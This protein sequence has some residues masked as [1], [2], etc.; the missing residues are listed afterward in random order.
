MKPILSLTGLLLS[1]SLWSN[2]AAAQAAPAPQPSSRTITLKESLKM[3]VANSPRLK[4]SGLEQ[5]RLQYNRKATTGAG[6]PQV[7]LSGSYDDYLALPTQMIPNIFS[8]PPRP[9]EKIPVQ[10]GTTY[11]IT[12]GLDISQVVYNQ[13][14][15]VGLR[16]ARQ[17]EQQ[18]ELVTE[19][20]TIDVVFDV[21][22][23][24]YL[25][26]ITRQ[27]IRNMQSN[28][29][30]IVKAERIASSQYDNG[31]IKKVDVDR[32]VVQKLN[33][34]TEVERLQVTY[35]QVLALQKYYMG[36]GQDEDFAPEDTIAGH[37]ISPGT[38]SDLSSHI[39]IRLIGMQENLVNTSI[40]LDQSGYFPSL[41]LIGSVNY[42]NQSNDFYLFGKPTDWFNTSLVGL[43]LSVPVF[44]GLQRHYKVSQTRVELEKLRVTEDDTKKLIRINS[45]DAARRLLNSTEAEKRQRENM[46]LAE[47]V[48]GIS[49]EQY[50]Q[51]MIP[52]TDLLNAETALSDAQSNHTYA[53]IQM[54][55]SEL[56]YLKANGKLLEILQ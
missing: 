4:I 16:M 31:L 46:Q 21:A 10:F 54:K 34:I 56:N 51:G 47:K 13:S 33:M 42:L 49:Q 55:L 50:Q 2:G 27:Q 38:E 44:S 28:L 52:L 32:I 25:A 36:L 5:I 22:Q 43:R 26:Q 30:K 29:E 20:T 48:Y 6:L 9:D 39:D 18:N 7:N 41:T 1:L 35:Q 8:D 11:N 12:G 24:Y 19:K 15:L 17:M 14:W 53:L 40:R 23:S 45:E 3:A 37:V